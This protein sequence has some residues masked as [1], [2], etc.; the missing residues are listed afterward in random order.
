LVAHW[1]H[2]VVQS[3]SVDMWVVVCHPNAEDGLEVA[4]H[5]VAIVGYETGLAETNHVV[6]I[7]DAGKWQ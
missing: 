7:A 1:K 4:D 6:I 2:G 5:L 3:K